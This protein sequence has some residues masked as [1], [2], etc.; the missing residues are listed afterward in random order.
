MEE[1]VVI[2]TVAIIVIMLTVLVTIKT[3]GILK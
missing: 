3:I 1:M 2:K